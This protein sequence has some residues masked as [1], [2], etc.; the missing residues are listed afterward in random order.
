MAYFDT[1]SGKSETA[2]M[3]I[4]MCNRIESNEQFDSA[5]HG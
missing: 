2:A 5:P 1:P 4:G 3:F